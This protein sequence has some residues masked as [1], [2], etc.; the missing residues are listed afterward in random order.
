M[1]ELPVNQQ[2]GVRLSGLAA[3]P[4]HCRGRFEGETGVVGRGSVGL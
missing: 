3:G 2:G 1:D 4:W